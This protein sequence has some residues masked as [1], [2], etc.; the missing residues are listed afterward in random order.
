MIKYFYSSCFHN[1]L[2]LSVDNYSKSAFWS[3][4]FA[5]LPPPTHHSLPQASECITH[6]TTQWF[7]SV[8]CGVYPQ[9]NVLSI[10]NINS[11]FTQTFIKFINK[12]K[13][14]LVRNHC[15]VLTDQFNLS[16]LIFGI[17]F[18]CTRVI[19]GSKN[20]WACLSPLQRQNEEYKLQ[21]K[22]HTKQVCKFDTICCSIFQKHYQ[23]WFNKLLNEY[24][25]TFD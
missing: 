11:C 20:G 13:D 12:Q 10:Q 7:V 23:Q 3:V 8:L 4:I 25:G 16:Y 18:I 19:I 2:S 24:S 5:P 6:L 1:Y 14:L 17:W 22:Q 9:K 21:H 15:I